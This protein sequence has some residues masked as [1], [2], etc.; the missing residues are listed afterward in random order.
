MLKAWLAVEMAPL[1][2]S[3][4]PHPTMSETL[5][6]VAEVFFGH[7]THVEH[8]RKRRTRHSRELQRVSNSMLSHAGT[9]L[10]TDTIPAHHHG[11]PRRRHMVQLM[12]KDSIFNLSMMQGMRFAGVPQRIVVACLAHIGRRARFVRPR[13][14]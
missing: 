12:G 10:R 3:I 9:S 7:S 2:L 4:H 5:M 13:V 6:E 1:K 14:A 11:Q 8:A